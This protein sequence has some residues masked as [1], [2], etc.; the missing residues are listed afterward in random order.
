MSIQIRVTEAD[1]SSPEIITTAYDKRLSET[2]NSSDEGVSFKAAKNDPKSDLLNPENGGYTRLWEAWDTET[3]ERVNRGPITSI[4]EQETNW[5]IEGKGRSAFLEDYISSRKVFYANIGNVIKSLRYEN[6]ASRPHTS[7]LVHDTKDTSDQTTIFGS[8]TIDEKYYGLSKSTKDNVIDDITVFPVNEVDRPNT[9]YRIDSFWSG[10]S[11]NDAIIVDLGEVLSVDIVNIFLP[12]WGGKQRKD[13]RGFDYSW[14]YAIDSGSPLVN[15][16]NRPFGPFTTYYTTPVGNHYNS[17]ARPFP[18]TSPIDMRYIRINITDVHAWYGSNFDTA[19]S[20]DGWDYQCNPDY[21][22]GSFSGVSATSKAIM[23]DPI[24]DRGLKD[25]N[26]C[27]ASVLEVQALQKFM[28]VDKVLPLALQRI[29]N[30][31]LQIKYYHTPDPAEIT[32]TSAGFRKFE[33]GSFFRRYHVSWS[34][35]STT[36]TKF[37]SS[38]CTNCYPDGFNFGIMDQDNTLIYSSDSSSGSDVSLKAPIWTRDIL[39][40]GAS[41][42]TVTW[43]DAWPSTTD[44]FSWGSSYS[45]TTID[46]DYA[47]VHFRGQSFKWYATVPSTKVGATCKVEI[48][49]KTTGTWSSWSTLENALVLP[50]GVASS[51]VYEITYESGYLQEDTTYEIKITN[52]DGGFASIDSFEGYWSASMNSYNEDSKRITLANPSA[53]VQINDQRY[54]NGSMYKWNKDN[55]MSMSFTGDR[56][57][58]TSYKGRNHG[59]MGIFIEKNT[60]GLHEYDFNLSNRVFIPGGD[61]STGTL[62]VNLETGKRG[63]E[64]PQYILF[65]SNDYFSSGLPWDSYVINLSIREPT[66]N[67]YQ[68][69]PSDNIDTFKRRCRDC[70]APTGTPVETSKWVFADSIIAHETVGLSVAFQDQTHLEQLKDI[71][72]A[73]QMEWDVTESG[74]RFEPRVGRDLDIMLR[75]GENTVV[76]YEIVNDITKVATMLFSEGAD[77][78]G[79]PLTTVVE[80]R[81]NRR[82]I[83]RTIM[84]K[85]D[86]RQ[87]SSYA[88]LIGVSR[89]ELKRRKYPEKRITVTHVARQLDLRKGDSF[90]LYTK[91][92][93][94][95]RVRVN[96][97][98]IEESSSGRMYHLECIKW[99]QIV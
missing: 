34:G 42:A 4:S 85:Q 82:I 66:T 17:S 44:S 28:E 64:I 98:E 52:L 84:R 46:G 21:V 68:A 95:L 83:G 25:E 23:T 78:D 92:L 48:R 74:L 1:G 67:T 89:T 73:M 99:P 88:Q 33:P 56:V 96:H 50:S 11:K 26:D 41:D 72:E 43:C 70:V 71:A 22:T 57:I 14:A 77:I 58:V 91:K 47:I 79:I 27:H 49:S 59:K 13:D 76:Q 39:M 15:F 10:M 35:A 38:D 8:V 9:Y 97:R 81:S 12:W 5:T 45:H 94:K 32:T 55:F 87:L 51:V 54:S 62:T 29:D 19:D 40:K 18:L 30:D 65:D 53:T 20:V 36:Y 3:N 75:E 63:E 90:I 69:Y 60:S 24:S 37:F 61:P 7:T 31:N 86:F 93:G 6:L 2:I 80:D 16:Q